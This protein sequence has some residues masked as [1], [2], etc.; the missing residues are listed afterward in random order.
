MSYDVA[1]L[2]VEGLF[3]VVVG[4]DGRARRAPL[5]LL[6]FA[7]HC[8]GWVCVGGGRWE[9]GGKVVAIAVVEGR[10]V[11]WYRDPLV[12]RNFLGS[13][14]PI[15]DFL[16]G[17]EL[18][19][20]LDHGPGSRLTRHHATTPP[21]SLN[22]MKARRTMLSALSELQ[23]SNGLSNQCIW[24]GALRSSLHLGGRRFLSSPFPPTI[25]PPPGMLL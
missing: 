17:L 18:V 12:V 8:R 23:L 19:I 20:G 16:V 1:A 6:E 9:V 4:A 7:A 13:K 11:G 10:S 5:A 24:A 22:I 21:P 2:G 25:P 3:P 15:R 14:L